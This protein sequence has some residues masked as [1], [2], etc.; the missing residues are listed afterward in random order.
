MLLK[1]GS[2][3]DS[4]MST[5]IILAAL[6]LCLLSLG[7]IARRDCVRWRRPRQRVLAQVVGHR[8]SRLEGYRQFAAIYRFTA[9]GTDHEVVDEVL[10]NSSQPPVGTPVEL[11]F[12]AGRPELARRPRF[13][14]WLSVYVLLAGMVA[15]L[16]ARLF[17]WI[18]P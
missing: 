6:A 16:V 11:V 8:T 4:G 9:E 7:I 1:P 14:M 15:I 3:I 13:L 12:P 17:G 5:V 2:L 10:S 18:G